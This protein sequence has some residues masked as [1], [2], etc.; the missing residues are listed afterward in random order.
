MKIKHFNTLLCIAMA[1]WSIYNM[2]QYG[3]AFYLVT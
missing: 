3:Q 1:C 2:D